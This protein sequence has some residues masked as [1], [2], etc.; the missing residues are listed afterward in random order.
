MEYALIRADPE[1]AGVS[2]LV[3]RGQALER[4]RPLTARHLVRQ[5]VLADREATID[6]LRNALTTAKN[7]LARRSVLFLTLIEPEFAWQSEFAA[8]LADYSAGVRIF[9]M[10]TG[11]RARLGS[12][13]TRA[14]LL[15]LESPAK[16]A[17]QFIDRLVALWD[18][19]TYAFGYT[20]FVDDLAALLPGPSRPRLVMRGVADPAF[21]KQRPFTVSPPPPLALESL[22]E[23]LAEAIRTQHPVIVRYRNE[24]GSESRLTFTPRL[25]GTSG[26]EWRVLGLGAN[27]FYCLHLERVIAFDGNGSLLPPPT[28]TVKAGD[29]Y[30]HCIQVVDVWVRAARGNG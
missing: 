15:W 30:Q 12:V 6:N 8:S 18:E 4:I 19:G 20:R 24:P 17:M 22:V 2:I 13:S 21:E 29:H 1:P 3:G 27:Q 23:N 7:G 11:S 10:C 5:V 14:S 25:L 26:G 16:E 28:T 9:G